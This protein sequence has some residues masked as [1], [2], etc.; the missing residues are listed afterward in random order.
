MADKLF[1]VPELLEGVLRALPTKDL[2]FAQQVCKHW[3]AVINTSA[4]LQKALFLR[5]GVAADTCADAELIDTRDSDVPP[6]GVAMNPLLCD[7]LALEDG[8]ETFEVKRSRL[9]KLRYGLGSGSKMQLT[10]P[11]LALSAEYS[12]HCSCGE[13]HTYYRRLREGCVFDD[14]DSAVEEVDTGEMH[15]GDEDDGGYEPQSIEYAELRVS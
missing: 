10:Q 3:Q 11:P 12:I 14:V 5:P 2:L 6:G 13:S 8:D 15:A 7:F 4:R 9:A 1:A